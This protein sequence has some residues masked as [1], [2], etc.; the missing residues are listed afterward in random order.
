MPLQI[1]GKHLCFFNSSLY[2]THVHLDHRAIAD[3]SRPG[4]GARAVHIQIDRSAL[5]QAY[6]AIELQLLIL[7]ID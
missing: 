4:E 1:T 2:G 3:D 5:T 6:M 7:P